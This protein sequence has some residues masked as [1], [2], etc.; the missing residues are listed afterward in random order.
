MSPMSRKSFWIGLA[1]FLALYLSLRLFWLAGDPGISAVWEYGYN[2]T[3]EGY[4]LGGGKEKLL[5]NCF[6]DLSRTEAFTYGFFAGTHFLSYLAHLVFGLSTWTWRIPFFLI[7]CA[8]WIVSYVYLARK[9]G[10]L[11]AALLCTAVSSVPM[12]VAYERTASNDVLIGALIVIAYVIATGRSRWRIFAAAAV[13]GLVVLVKPSVWALLPIVAA[14]VLQRRKFSSAMT[15]VAV[16]VLSAF[17]AVFLCKAL[18]AAAVLPDAHRAGV[19]VW[20]IIR[21]TTTHYPLPD[22][23]D[24]ASHFKGISAF[25]RD[26]SYALLGVTSVF[27]LAL[28]VAMAAKNVCELR[29]DAGTLLF[30]SVAAYVAAI[31]VMNTQYTHY[32]IPAVMMLPIL[33][34][35][36]AEELGREGD[37]FRLRTAL[38]PLGITLAACAVGLLFLAAE[39]VSPQTAQHYYSRIYNFPSRNVWG[40]SAPALAVFVAMVVAALVVLRGF[41]E[42]LAPVLPE[43]AIV[44]GE[45]S[46]QMLMSLPV[47]T[48]TT[49]AANSD[50]IPVIRSILA[51]EPDA[52]LYALVDSQH[53]YNLQH[54]R[55]HADEY[56][57]QPLKTLRMPSFATGEPADV[58]LC[59]IRVSAREKGEVK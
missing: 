15:D 26:P 53:A 55:E 38:A 25:P 24:F 41:T 32:F 9:S 1:A 46:S 37:G 18:A 51:A 54:Y 33:L 30:A 5:W 10:A 58:H 11:N 35:A 7:T 19:G 43:D 21:R 20:E 22:L 56:A 47:R 14:G 57:L 13:T 48:A 4:Y 36:A 12:I 50:P 6:V 40:L 59:R 16:F 52:K 42:A 45:R 2:A 28:P 39:T 44:I 23:L 49:F 31:N 29:F 3:D 27:F 17:A 34:D 8:A